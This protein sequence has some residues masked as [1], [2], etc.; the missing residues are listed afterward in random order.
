MSTSNKQNLTPGQI[1]TASQTELIVAQIVT[2]N[3]GARGYVTIIS[4]DDNGNELILASAS[5]HDWTYSDGNVHVPRNTASALVK[6]DQ[7]YK[8]VS[9][10]TVDTVD[11]YAYYEAI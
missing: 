6:K 7:K 9:T 5:V 4:I 3:N 11:V 1:Y 10:P 2:K 8:V